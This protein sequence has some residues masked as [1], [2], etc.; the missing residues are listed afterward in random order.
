MA[1]T[2]KD[3]TGE[4]AGRP[5]GLRVL[6]VED[7]PDTLSATVELLQLL[8]HWATGVRS[9]EIAK[10]RFLDGAFDVLL[11]DVGLPALSGMDLVES[12]RARHKVEVIFAT[13]RPPPP[14]PIP[15]SF[16]LQK[17]FSVEQLESAL[18]GVM[19][20]AEA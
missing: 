6:V 4:R 17:P 9:A 5:K 16:W 18:A 8:G 15:H 11:T 20:R 14:E 12:L 2:A 13:G 10:D 7:D 1:N 3:A 19:S